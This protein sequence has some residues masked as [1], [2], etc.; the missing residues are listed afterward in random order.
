MRFLPGHS[1]RRWELTQHPLLPRGGSSGRS[2]CQLKAASVGLLQ[3]CAMLCEM[4]GALLAFFFGTL[5]GPC[6]R[7]VKGPTQK[8]VEDEPGSAYA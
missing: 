7:Q 8:H 3:S 4:T 1:H 6:V 5:V 2:R